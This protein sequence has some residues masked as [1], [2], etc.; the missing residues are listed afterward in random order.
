[1]IFQ[2][3][4]RNKFKAIRKLQNIISFA[5]CYIVQT[6]DFRKKKFNFYASALFN[7]D[8]HSLANPAFWSIRFPLCWYTLQRKYLNIDDIHSSETYNTTY[9]SSRKIE[10]HTGTKLKFLNKWHEK[11]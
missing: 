7:K 8:F 5:C 6:R 2:D 10:H 3:T 9:E 4:N 11:I 1:M